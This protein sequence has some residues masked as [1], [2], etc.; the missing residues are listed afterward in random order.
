MLQYLKA[1]ENLHLT[2]SEME[3][4]FGD[5]MAIE[6]VT[7]DSIEPPDEEDEDPAVMTQ[8]EEEA[9]APVATTQPEGGQATGAPEAAHD[10]EAAD[11]ILAGL[12]AGKK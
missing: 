2:R 4:Y 7:Y 11:D 10:G 9:E 12:I 3:R 6:G 1:A 8:P 5:V